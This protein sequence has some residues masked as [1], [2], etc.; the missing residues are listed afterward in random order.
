MKSELREKHPHFFG[1]WQDLA[2]FTRLAGSP[3][4]SPERSQALERWEKYK[5][6]PATPEE[7]AIIVKYDEVREEWKQISRKV[8]DGRTSDSRK[9]RRMAID[10]SLGIAKKKFSWVR[11]QG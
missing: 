6:L 11:A 4:R 2:Q 8:V 9:G 10:L 5:A 3:I 1:N 7:K